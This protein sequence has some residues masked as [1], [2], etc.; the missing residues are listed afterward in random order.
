MIR[1]TI[2][3]DH[4]LLVSGLKTIL[5]SSSHI[6]IIATY[7]NGSELLEGLK[8]R[9]PD[10]LLTD[11][12][13][14][15]K[16]FG[17]DLIRAIRRLY[18]DLPVLVLSGQET[19]FNVQDIMAQGCKG[20]LLKNSTDP[21]MLVHAIEEVYNDQLFIEPSLRDKL[22]Q[23]VFKA[24]KETEEVNSFLSRRE[25]EILKLIAIGHSNQEMADKLYLSIRTIESHR[26][27]LLQKLDVKNVAGLLKKAADMGL[28][29]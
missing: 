4:A 8:T 15:G 28:L 26:L 21:E 27:R 24:K 25:K 19:L 23:G 11:L 3:D 6:E 17:I 22:L 7:T 1:I 5:K 20:Y 14:P 16:I 13:M 2:T 10:V 12:Q 9:Q 18:P 29:D